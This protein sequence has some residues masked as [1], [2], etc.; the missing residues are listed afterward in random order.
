MLI[1]NESTITCVH[2]TTH[3]I[4]NRKVQNR[5]THLKHVDHNIKELTQSVSYLK[6]M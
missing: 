5:N 6:S 1:Q 2:E 4:T 3:F